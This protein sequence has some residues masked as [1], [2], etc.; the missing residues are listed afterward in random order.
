MENWAVQPEVPLLTK[1]KKSFILKM[2]Y[3]S[4]QFL[5]NYNSRI[6]RKA[7]LLISVKENP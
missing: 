3:S 5:R 2:E 7:P 1:F 6:G 4:F